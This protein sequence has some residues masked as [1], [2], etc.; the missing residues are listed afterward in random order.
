M[1]ELIASL[2]N[3]THQS[4]SAPQMMVGHIEGAFL[5]LL[6]RIT[7]AN[8]I[9][10]IGTFTGYSSLA[11]AEGLPANGKLITLDVSKQST[12]IAKKYWEKSPHGSKIKSILGPALESIET[13]EESFDMA[14]IDADKANYINYY[15]AILP[16]LN[17][18]GLIVA[19]NTLWSGRVL[20]PEAK[21]DHALAKFNHHVLSDSRVECVLLTVRDGMMLIWKK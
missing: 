16:K 2:V 18:G 14:F 1:P 17:Q 3:E 11:M 12:D 19:D 13:L 20:Q 4:T 8:Q 10:E 6:V 9:L 5:R 15:E 7:R 21:S